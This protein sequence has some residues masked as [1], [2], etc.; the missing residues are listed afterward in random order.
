MQGESES[1]DKGSTISNG[2]QSSPTVYTKTPETDGS[3]KGERLIYLVGG[4]SYWEPWIRIPQKCFSWCYL[5]EVYGWRPPLLPTT[6]ACGKSFTID[7]ALNCPTEGFL[8]ISH[9]EVQDLTADLLSEV[10]HNVCVKPA[11]QLLTGEHI[12]CHCQQRELSPTRCKSMWILG[13]AKA[14]CN[15]WYKGVHPM[16]T[17]MPRH[18]DGCLLQK[19]WKSEVSSVRTACSWGW[20]RLFHPP[21]IQ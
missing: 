1:R 19:T 6:F 18:T 14:E 5:F 8:I 13:T 9:N 7:H 15:Y 10:C 4:T 21:S 17:V 2:W 3:C 16:C 11:L 20:A 12:T